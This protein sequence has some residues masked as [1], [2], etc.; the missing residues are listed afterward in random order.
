MKNLL[1]ACRRIICTFRVTYF[2]ASELPKSSNH[3]GISPVGNLFKNGLLPD[4]F[5]LFLSFQYTVDSKQ[6]YDINKFLPMTGFIPRT[7]GI[8]SNRSTN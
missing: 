7:S 1:T 4:S 2:G 5:Y 6:M 3:L 8:G